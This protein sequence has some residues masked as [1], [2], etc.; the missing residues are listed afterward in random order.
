MTLDPSTDEIQNETYF[1]G[2]GLP[3]WPNIIG[4]ESVF[5]PAMRSL[6]VCEYHVQIS[7][8]NIKICT[9]VTIT[10]YSATSVRAIIQTAMAQELLKVG[11]LPL[12]GEF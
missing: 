10:K 7:Q 9:S 4:T 2:T 12:F 6:M 5:A 1:S 8:C 11:R 3:Q